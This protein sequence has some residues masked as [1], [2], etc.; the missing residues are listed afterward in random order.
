M[1]SRHHVLHLLTNRE[2]FESANAYVPDPAFAMVPVR[3]RLPPDWTTLHEG[4]WFHCLPPG[5][6]MPRQG[7]KIHVSGTTHTAHEL[8]A[9]VVP[10]LV[11]EGVAFKLAAD[12]I[13]LSLINSKRWSRGGSGKFMTVYPRDA[14]HFTALL[15]RLHAVTRGFAGPYILSDR[16]YPESKVL[17]YRYGTLQAQ[18]ALAVDGRRVS[19]FVNDDG[20]L[21]GDERSPL[22]R[23]PRGITDPIAPEPPPHAPASGEV[24]LHDGRYRVEASLAFSNS[25]GVYLATDTTTDATVVLKEARP[26]TNWLSRDDD[27]AALLRKE[28]R[29]LALLAGSGYTARPI[30]LFS[31]WEHTFVAQEYVTG[32]SLAT[33]GATRSVLLRTRPAPADVAAFLD[34]TRR[35]FGSLLRALEH[36]H[37]R[38]VVFGDLSPSNVLWREELGRVALIDFEGACELGVDRPA[39]LT[40]PGFDAPGAG[41]AGTPDPADDWYA[42]GALLCAFLMPITPFFALAPDRVGPIVE[43]L[44]AATYLPPEITAMARAL[45]VPEREHRIGPAQI[46]AALRSLEHAAA[47]FDQPATAPLARPTALAQPAPPPLDPALPARLASYI[48]ANADPRRTDR[49]YPADFRV[50]DTNPHSLSFGAA[51][52]L[53]ALHRSGI[54]PPAEQLDWL[55]RAEIAPARYPPG[56]MVGSSGI[57]WALLELGHPDAARRALAAGH[58]HPLRDRAAGLAHGKAGWAL[59]N[60]KFFLALHDERYLTEARRCADELLR[61][62]TTVPLLRDATAVELPRSATAADTGLSWPAEDDTHYGLFHGA[63][64]VALVLA[65][66]AR[67]TGEERY[68]AGARRALAFDLAQAQPIENGLGVSWPYRA[69]FPGVLLPYWSYGSAGIGAALLRV[70]HLCGADDLEPWLD[71]I[72]VDTDRAFAVTTGMANGLAGIATFLTDAHHFTGEQRYR[73]AALR[74]VDGILTYRVERPTGLALPGDYSGRISCDYATG[75]AGVL[76]LAHRLLTNTPTDFFLDEYFTDTPYLRSRR[77]HDAGGGSQR[78]A[79]AG[80]RE[81]I[82]RQ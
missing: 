7:W 18:T 82:V 40:T 46:A 20:T 75:S 81:P 45:L 71:R 59:T 13:L 64:G 3:A 30:E 8:L 12:R 39:N 51:G 80:C 27:A 24:R 69:N 15:A 19:V 4:V 66:L 32:T 68:A 22:F 77:P 16:R 11:N 42:Y 9:A 17:F 73:T 78:S 65:Y 56:L 23:L 53:Y 35:V 58:D 44:G 76:R 25:G 29:I 28:Q 63:S 61:D 36:L 70:I 67:T 21:E 38:N 49:L 2:W 1:R 52:V 54:A 48:V 47:T 31:E 34:L 37:A 72:F 62:A 43:K 6:A 55:L 10:V 33:L 5:G 14:D 50:F 57:A 41:P 60:L 74:A 26:Y 79:K